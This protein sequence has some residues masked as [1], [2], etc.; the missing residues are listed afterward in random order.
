M[1]ASVRRHQAPIGGVIHAAA[2]LSDA[3]LARLSAEDLAAA[4]APKLGGAWNLHLLTRDDP[5]DLFVLFSSAATAI[6]NPGQAA[7]VAANHALEALAR[8]RRAEG[9]PALAIGWGP[10]A[11]AGMLARAPE[12]AKRL[13]THLGLRPI[14]V[15]EATAALPDLLASPHPAVHVADLE[16][17]QA[18]ARLAILASPTFAEARLPD[19]GADRGR[20]GRRSAPS[21]RRPARGG[22]ARLARGGP[23][24]R[25][26]Q[27]ARPRRAGG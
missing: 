5:L 15:R 21:P 6:G 14:P 3:T 16:A 22:G 2:V 26:R 10:I 20:G 1:L 9:L 25:G 4:L 13:E 18:R 8:A 11:G 27:G 19:D 12:V 7:Y 17:A 24:R 23:R